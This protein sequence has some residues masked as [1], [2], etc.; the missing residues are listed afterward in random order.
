MDDARH[1]PQEWAQPV[2]DQVYIIAEDPV[3]EFSYIKN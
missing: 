1:T 2:K 3:R